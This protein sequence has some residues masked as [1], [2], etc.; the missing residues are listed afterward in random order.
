M[1]IAID[2]FYGGHVEMEDLGFDG[3]PAATRRQSDAH[4]ATVYAEA[5]RFADVM[6]R[7]GYDTLWLAEHHFQREGY[8]CISNVPLLSLH[9]AHLTRDLKFG[10]FFNTITAWHPLRLAEDF[11]SVDVLTGGRL[12]FGIGRGYIAREVETLGSPLLDDVANREI[13]EEQVEIMMRAWHEPQFAHSGAAYRIPADVP[14]MRD[15]LVDI[16]LVP[17]PTHLPV[18]V[19]QPITSAKQRGFDFMARY[20]IKGVIAGGTSIGGRAEQ[21]AAMYRDG[22]ARAGRVTEL[23]EDLAVGFQ[24]H[25]ADTREAA[26][27]EASPWFEEQL[28][29]LAPLNRFPDFTDA[30][31]RA[32]AEGTKARTVGLPTIHDVDAEGSWVCGPPNYVRDHVM[33][34]LQRMPGLRRVFIQTGSLGVPPSAMRADLEW[35]AQDIMPSIQSACITA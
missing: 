6:D 28:K 18:E 16:T 15:A 3:P 34:L 4:L 25:L 30:Q 31:V 20:G 32:T 7:T 26:L 1:T 33:S 2:A 29:G 14:H 24:M 35:F 12:R 22:L 5:E 8:G 10:A 13:F 19:W 17:R 11:A 9:L 21:A 27:Q 23:G